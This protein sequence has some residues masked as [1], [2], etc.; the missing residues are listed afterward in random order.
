MTVRGERS[1]IPLLAVVAAVAIGVALWHLVG[2]TAGLDIVRTRV[3]TIPVTV[4]QPGAGPRGPAVVIAHGFAGSQQLMQPFAITLARNGYT[5]VTFDFPGHGRNPAPLPGGIEDHEAAGRALLAA[6]DAVVDFARARQIGDGRVAL[7]GHSMA[8][9][10]VVRRAVRHP[11]IAATV[12]VSLFSNDVTPEL[13]RNLLV[14]VG[15]LEPAMLK[16]EGYRIAGMAARGA[17]QEGVTYG[18]IAVGTGRRLA[19]SAGVEHIGVL[20]SRDSMN[21]VLAWMN[22]V[23][24]RQSD[25]FVDAR[26]PWLALLF[27]GIVALAY[28]LARRLPV[29]ARPPVGGGF[30]WRELLPVAIVPALL[31]PLVLWKLPTH[32]LPLLLGDYVACHFALYGVLT[33]AGLRVISRRRARQ[34]SHFERASSVALALS[35]FAVTMFCVFAIA[36]PLDQFVTCFLPGT[37]RLTM[38]LAMLCGTLPYFLAD[39]WLTRGLEAARGAYAVT[40]ILFLLSLALAIAL[41]PGRLFF[42]IIIVPAILVLFVTHGLIAHWAWRRT[43]HPYPGAV[44]NAF[45]FAWAMAVTFPMV[46]L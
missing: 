14:I 43:Q 13:P 35:V 30:S 5:A 38:M 6:L 44:A 37:G 18:D 20:Y 31:T 3:G 11:D 39:A 16:A 8:S 29:V 1:A 15:A 17:A 7:L 28:A 9:E 36:L 26:G 23:F 25:G 42:L 41:N 12:G 10:I 2:A 46:S 40:K 4:F 22:Q 33:A 21:E 24:S 45:A 34:R 19:L 32:F 27:L